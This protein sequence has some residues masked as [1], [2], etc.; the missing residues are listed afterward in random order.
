[1]S[2]GAGI[3]AI[4]RAQIGDWPHRDN[5]DPDCR[6]ICALYNLC[7]E[8]LTV[9]RNLPTDVEVSPRRDAR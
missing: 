3:V 5:H 9:C 2:V 1:L 6:N 8:R 7:L 4:I